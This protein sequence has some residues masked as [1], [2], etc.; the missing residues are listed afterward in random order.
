MRLRAP[1]SALETPSAPASGS[2]AAVLLCATCAVFHSLPTH[3]QDGAVK[4]PQ[5]IASVEAQIQNTAARLKAL[6]EQLAINRSR[7][8]S[9]ESTVEAVTGKVSERQNRLQ[10][11]GN[12]IDRYNAT[13]AS[14]EAQVESERAQ[15]G[16]RKQTLADS[17]RRQQNISSSTGLRM[18]L[19][20]ENPSTV[21]RLGV[22]ADF[23]VRAQNQQIRDQLAI[24]EKVEQAH[25]T[26]LKDRN[27]LNHIERKASSQHQALVQQ[28]QQVSSEITTVEADIRS[29]TK[30]VAELKADTARLQSLMEEL[31][32]LQ[33]A[34]SGYFLSGRGTYEFPV[35]GVIKARFDDVK[36]VGKIRWQG[37]FIAASEGSAV[38]AVADGEIVYSAWLQ[39][40]GL[41]V[42][43]DHGDSFMTLYGGNRDTLVNVGDWVD[44]GRPVATVGSSGGHNSPGLYF[45]IRHE[46]KPVDPEQWVKSGT[47]S[48][49][50]RK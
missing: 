40:F 10:Q 46:A 2:L 16:E 3:A 43:I 24:I 42:I 47:G 37:L 4:K 18:V 35:E 34:D 5:D 7:K 13:L 12:E 41:L 28:R 25:A 21:S 14:L 44:A 11:L 1:D 26:A 45:E 50:A 17:I 9:L 15:L 48:T 23:L 39:G 27:W 22:Y 31:K 38:R 32:A 30:T 36:S 49:T 29:T 33:V 20:H 6:D 19:Q 8:A